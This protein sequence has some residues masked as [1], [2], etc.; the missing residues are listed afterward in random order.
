MSISATLLLLP[1]MRRS[2][3]DYS[4]AMFICPAPGKAS[5]GTDSASL[6]TLQ[7][8]IAFGCSKPSVTS[9]ISRLQCHWLRFITFDP[10][11]AKHAGPI[12]ICSE[13]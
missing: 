1:C 4:F 2:Y 7:V 12:T 10:K 13:R 8:G 3:E 9:F 5:T 6:M 11:H